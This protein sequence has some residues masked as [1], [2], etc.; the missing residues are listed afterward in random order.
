[1]KKIYILIAVAF[2]LVACK[3]GFLDKTP[4]DKLSED[5]VFNSDALA[6][7]YVNAL[8]TVLPDPY[9]EGNIGCI[10]D[11]GYFRYGGTSTRYIASG[12]MDPDNVMYMKEGGQA[13]NTRTTVLNIWNRTYEWIYRMNYFLTYI[14][15]HGSKMSES[16]KARLTGEVHFLRAWSYFLLIQRYS[17]VPLISKP[18]SLDDDF[19]VERA[20]FDTC[21]DFILDDLQQAYELLPAK[22]DAA[23]GRINKDVVLA[24]RSRLTLVA[25]SKLF[26]DPDKPQ[27]GIFRGTYS[28][29][30]WQRAFDAAK[31]I[32]DRAEVDGA[33]SLDDTYDGIWKD[34]NSPELIWAKYFVATSDADD[35]YTKKAQLLYTVEYYNGWESFH[36]TQAAQIDFEMKNGKKW[37]EE[38]SGYDANHPYKNRDPRFYYCIA[39]PFY[40]YGSTDKNGSY[41]EAPLLLYYLY[42]GMTRKDFEAG[43]PEPAYTSKA[44]HTT[45]GNHGG[46]ELYKWY[47]PTEYISESQT[48]SKLYPWF[49]LAEMYLNYAEAAYMLGKEDICREYIN[50]IRQRPDVMMPEVTESGSDLWDRLVNERRVELYAEMFRYFDLRRWKLADFYENVPLASAKTMVLQNGTQMDTVYRVARLYDPAKNNTNYYW[51]N[52]DASKSY[53]YSGYKGDPRYGKPIEY[54]VTYK[55]LGKEYTIDYGDCVLNQNPTPRYF[56]EDGRNY[57]MPIPRNEITKSEGKLLQNP[58]YPGSE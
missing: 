33:Y 49:R 38:G 54:I 22:A 16:A 14:E 10:T 2:A 55:W 11:E 56:P 9:Q 58:G 20:D 35:N 53:V 44:K 25:A 39:A 41:S 3:D 43:T 48:G 34:V 40:P 26:N 13:H 24:L 46:L 42:D 21:V 31:A 29:D 5:A 6:E 36:P 45:S 51:T 57:L 7:S 27:G 30:K 18:H 28:R 50:K 19:T 1:M 37:F 12:F 47:L 32:V 8:Y 15:D 4:L 52:T 17:G 23:K